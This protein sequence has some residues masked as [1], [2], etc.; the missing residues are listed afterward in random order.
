MAILEKVVVVTTIETTE[1]TIL[2]HL[3]SVA[4]INAVLATI[5]SS[6]GSAS[7]SI[8]DG[9]PNIPWS[10]IAGSTLYAYVD[11]IGFAAGGVATPGLKPMGTYSTSA[12][13]K[14]NELVLNNGSTY[15]SKQNGNL[16]NAVTDTTW[17]ELFAAKGDQGLEGISYYTTNTDLGTSS[18]TVAVSAV[19]VPSGRTV[20]V[21]DT[22]QVSASNSVGNQFRVTAVASGNATIAYMGTVRGV[23]GI[24][25]IQ[26]VLGIQGIQ[27][28]QGI[29]GLEGLSNYPTSA[30]LAVSGTSTITTST[31]TVP[32]G[33]TLKIGDFVESNHASSSSIKH[34]ITA[35]SGSDITTTFFANNKGAKG[36]TGANGSNYGYVAGR[37]TGVAYFNTSYDLTEAGEHNSRVLSFRLKA[38]I[39][40]GKSADMQVTGFQEDG[41]IVP[42]NWSC[43]GYC[44]INLTISLFS[45]NGKLVIMVMHGGLGN[46]TYEYA[47]FLEGMLDNDNHTPLSVSLTNSIMGYPTLIKEF[48][49][50][51]NSAAP[52]FTTGDTAT[53]AWF[54]TN[55]PQVPSSRYYFL[56]EILYFD[57]G[58]PSTGADGGFYKAS[59]VAKNEAGTLS[60]IR[61]YN[62]GNIR[63]NPQILFH[64]GVVNVKLSLSGSAHN[65][66]PI[67]KVTRGDQPSG[68]VLQA[69]T[70]T[71]VGYGTTGESGTV[72]PTFSQL[73]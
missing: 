60:I 62:E 50:L 40:G 44:D 28:V 46:T 19:N 45:H 15:R 1:Y 63:A 53:N 24:Q 17:W 23:Q 21:G 49:V 67:V 72:T 51:N 20:K 55:L 70:G 48:K 58:V 12:N 34:R 8:V 35:I 69:V 39:A 16:N 66:T 22:I 26:G 6:K 59:I 36:D 43:G 32:S 31:I 57:T 4:E 11:G 56:V 47:C 73:V 14:I 33:R 38:T 54:I 10:G 29:Q 68:V 71:R 25:G 2:K 5:P 42:N 52:G 37:T 9:K 3:G 13:Y 64:S 27:G 30:Q 7:Y 65:Y 61:A 41:T 18:T